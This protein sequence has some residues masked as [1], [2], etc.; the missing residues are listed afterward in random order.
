MALQV[1][2]KWKKRIVACLGDAWSAERP[3]DDSVLAST[4]FSREGSAT[5]I[6]L[7]TTHE[8][9]ARNGWRPHRIVLLVYSPRPELDD[10]AVGY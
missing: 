7:L 1:Q 10:A 3:D 8:V 4:V 9:T 2:A 5:R 6:R